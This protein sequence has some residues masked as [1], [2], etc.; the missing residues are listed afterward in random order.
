VA[1]Y[2]CFEESQAT[3][4]RRRACTEGTRE[5]VLSEILTWAKDFS[6]DSPQL[7]WLDGLAGTGKST[8]AFSICHSLAEIKM[9]GASFFCSRQDEHASREQCIIPT[10]VERLSY[11]S[12][13]FTR[14]LLSADTDSVNG[15]DR[16]MV[17]LLVDPWIES[18]RTR[19]ATSSPLVVVVDALDEN[20]GGGSFLQKLV[21][22]IHKKCLRG[23]KFLVTSRPHPE[24]V[25]ACQSFPVYHLHHLD[26][27]IVN[28]DIRT[29]LEDELRD[30]QGSDI[31]EGIIRRADGFFIYAAT[32]I[33]LTK[34]GSVAKVSILEKTAK[35]KAMLQTPAADYND[36][37]VIELYRLIIFEAFQGLP[38]ENILQR[39]NV[40]RAILSTEQQASISI[41][42]RFALVDED[43]VRAV[44]HSLYA[45]LYLSGDLISWYHASF[46][47]MMFQ[48]DHFSY[49]FTDA[50]TDKINA[51]L[52]FLLENEQHAYLSHHCFRIMEST[53]HFDLASF[54]S[55][56]L[57]DKEVPDL[58]ERFEKHFDSSLEYSMHHWASHLIK[59]AG[60][61]SAC[62]SALCNRLQTFLERRVLFWLEAIILVRST[63]G[64]Q[65][66]GALDTLR[67]AC[68]WLTQVC[69]FRL[70]FVSLY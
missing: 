70:L 52:H 49:L 44:V 46:A 15:T 45:V 57:E 54:P 1:R 31:L 58:S 51:K 13:S 3:T 22:I 65:L 39:L 43:T 5:E 20:T 34:I 14:L 69:S 50:F 35:L 30:L 32:A 59:S 56:F 17:D 55:S 37:R 12:S 62:T 24:I 19:M 38:K 61:S 4:F 27:S 10:I 42:A 28:N 23:L 60:V 40:L 53:L 6:D 8:I 7:Y 66:S 47:D 67:F 63:R 2:D 29:Y 11:H 9:L 26:R 16:Q 48:A 41:I 25:E 21:R 36:H 64:V 68:E 18:Y 33:R